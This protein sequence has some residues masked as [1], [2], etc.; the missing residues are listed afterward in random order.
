MDEKLHSLALA[1]TRD[2][3]AK[4]VWTAILASPTIQALIHSYPRMEALLDRLAMYSTGPTLYVDLWLSGIMLPHGAAQ[5]VSAE[6]THWQVLTSIGFGQAEAQLRTRRGDKRERIPEQDLYQ[7]VNHSRYF[8]KG[9][10]VRL[11]V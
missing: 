10:N 7:E 2:E 1:S 6:R 3:H 8:F 4:E 5:L 11:S 9:V